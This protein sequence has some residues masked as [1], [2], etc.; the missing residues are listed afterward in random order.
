MKNKKLATTIAI[1]ITKGFLQRK[2]ITVW[3]DENGNLTLLWEDELPA[4][5]K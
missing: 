3:V 2:D 4:S 1:A 5:S